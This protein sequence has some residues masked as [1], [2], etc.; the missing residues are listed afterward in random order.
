M[1]IKQSHAICIEGHMCI[2]NRHVVHASLT[3]NQSSDL[4]S[5]TII[6]GKI[7]ST[8]VQENITKE[9][10]QIYPSKPFNEHHISKYKHQIGI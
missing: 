7:Q 3:K 10:L 5:T 6:K 9:G 4:S 2:S 1:L 8:L